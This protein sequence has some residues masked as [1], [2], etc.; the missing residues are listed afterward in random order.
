[1]AL[2]F[3]SKSGSSIT[4]EKTDN[5]VITV[6]DFGKLFRLNLGSNKIFTLPS[7]GA[8]EDGE[9]LDLTPIDTGN[10]I[11]S[12]SDSDKVGDNEDNIITLSEQGQI[13]RVTYADAIITW[14]ITTVG[15]W[16][17]TV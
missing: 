5:Y 3:G 17:T 15:N 11:L 8:G 1:M 16:S 4:F 14:Q 12:T 7:V 6:K 9:F 13:Y 10:I 2:I